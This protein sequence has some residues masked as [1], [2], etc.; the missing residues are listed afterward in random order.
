MP[1]GIALADMRVTLLEA[2]GKKVRFLDEVVRE[3]G[4]ENV[5]AV[6]ARAEEYA[7]KE[8][9]REQFD[10]AVARALAP[11]QTLVEYTLPFVRVGGVALAYKAVE[12]E[13]ETR[14]A[15]N[16]I[17]TLGGRVREILPVKLGDLQDVRQLV[18]ID[19]VEPTPDI[20][21]RAGGLPKSQP[22]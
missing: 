9:Q 21:P 16:A 22:L 5:T 19:K 8:R 10:Y 4:L 13:E 11:M 2:T 14:R 12:A 6:H 20:Y 7:R 18:V 17:Q 15:K 3:L 1:L